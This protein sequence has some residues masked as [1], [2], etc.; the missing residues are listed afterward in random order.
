M[1]KVQSN[2]KNINLD[3]VYLINKLSIYNF[4]VRNLTLPYLRY[5]RWRRVVF[6]V[7]A[8]RFPPKLQYKKFI[9]QL[10]IITIKNK[11]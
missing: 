6:K 11:P 5:K 9:F 2:H 8:Y 4:S 1:S 3:E 10:N 7:V